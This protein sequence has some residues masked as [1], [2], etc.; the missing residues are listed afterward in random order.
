MPCPPLIEQVFRDGKR[1]LRYNFHP[2]QIRAWNST[3]RIVA[4]IA[5]VRS[6]KTSFGPPWLHREMILRGPGDYLVAAPSYPLIDKAAGPEI[7]AFFGRLLQLGKSSGRQFTISPDGHAKLWPHIP[8]DR[9]SRMIYGHADNPDSLAAMTA[10]AVWL[11]EAGQKRFRLASWEEVQRR[12]SFDRG[13]ILLTS[14]VYDLGWMKQKLYDPWEAARRNHD[15][16]DIVNFDSTENPAFPREE[17]ERAQ[18]ELPQWKFD[19][20]FRGR[21]SRPAGLI[22]DRFDHKNHVWPRCRIS[23]EWPRYGGLDFGAVNTAAV[24]LAAE[25]GPNRLPTG[26]YIAYREYPD[27]EFVAGKLAAET[28]AVNLLKGES[29]TPLFVGGSASEDEWRSKFRSAGLPVVEPPV[30]AV[31]VQID[32]VYRLIANNNLIVM[33]DLSGLLDQLASYSRE[34]DERGEPTE[35][36]DS[37]SIY[38]YLAALRYLAVWLERSG[39]VWQPTVS[40][41]GRDLHTTA[42]AGVFERESETRRHDDSDG[43]RRMTGGSGH[44]IDEMFPEF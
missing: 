13:R 12:V 38:H 22:Y 24:Y 18:R 29:T 4:V 32:A 2:G 31:E 40:E 15:E 6:G 44:W 36:I 3:K 25:L 35:K 16:I 23:D 41:S 39:G 17:Y 27:R 30:S 26:R 7:E 10:K 43:P 9:P 14:T 11:D 28:H 5:G 19:M 33:G 21:F 8:Y 20:F 34:L 42:P 1:G 37:D